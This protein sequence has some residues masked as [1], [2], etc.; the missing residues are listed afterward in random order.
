MTRFT[1]PLLICLALLTGCQAGSTIETVDNPV[2]EQITVS[3]LGACQ[4]VFVWE[5]SVWLYGDRGKGVVK[6][7]EWVG[8]NNDARPM[9]HDA[10]E[11]YELMLYRNRFSRTNEDEQLPRNLIPHPTGITHRPEFDAF[12]GSDGYQRDPSW[13]TG[14]VD[15]LRIYDRGLSADEVADLAS[16]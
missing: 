7:L 8:P 4:G 2:V 14:A 11:T 12:I 15:D 9:L 10:G 6:R 3:R 13:L 1:A 5:N 16:D